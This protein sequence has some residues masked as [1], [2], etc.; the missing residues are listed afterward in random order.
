MSEHVRGIYGQIGTYMHIFANVL[1]FM[2]IN[3]R[4][5]AYVM[6]MQM[7]VYVNIHTYRHTY[8]N[9]QIKKFVDKAVRPTNK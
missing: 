4:A 2:D 1:S 7:H 3:R 8:I 6:Y 9:I 5:F